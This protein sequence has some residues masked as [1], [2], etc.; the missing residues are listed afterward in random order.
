MIAFLVCLAI[1]IVALAL[2]DK[3]AMLPGDD[4]H[5]DWYK[6]NFPPTLS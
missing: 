6:D 2:F 3:F 1:L 4:D 5:D